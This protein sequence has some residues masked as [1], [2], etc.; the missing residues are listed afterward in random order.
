MVDPGEEARGRIPSLLTGF[1][2]RRID[3]AEM[4]KEISVLT[5]QD[6]HTVR[7]IGRAI[8]AGHNPDLRVWP[9]Y[10]DRDEIR[11]ELRT[12]ATLAGNQIW[13]AHEVLHPLNGEEDMARIGIHDEIA[14][15]LPRLAATRAKLE[16]IALGTD[17][18]GLAPIE[19]AHLAAVLT[20]I[21]AGRIQ[22]HKEL[23]E[24]MWADERSR[25]IV[26][27]GRQTH[28]GVKLATRTENR[29][30]ELAQTSSPVERETEQEYGRGAAAQNVAHAIY[31]VAGGV[32]LENREQNR[33]EDRDY[34]RKTVA[35][36]DKVL[37]R[38]GVAPTVKQVMKL[39]GR[40]ATSAA[41]STTAGGSGT[42][43][44]GAWSPLV[45]TPRP[46]AAPP[47]HAAAQAGPA[48]RAPTKPHGSTS[49]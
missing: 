13:R 26:D 41:S 19:R 44:P 25:S 17:P 24:L 37:S 32:G 49:S 15:D 8:V 36:L 48:P 45:T 9:G 27:S 40:Q 42:P 5:P 33:Q 16:A 38:Q 1:A 47:K 28:R 14:A 30:W 21:D 2:A 7:E 11:D 43:A 6:Q 46:N 34:Y 12:Y 20:D 22:H 3:P 23:P 35:D 31:K 29:I 10:A 39:P 4:T 18:N